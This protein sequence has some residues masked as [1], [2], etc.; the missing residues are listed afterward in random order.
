[1]IGSAVPASAARRTS[2]PRRWPRCTACKSCPRWSAASSGIRTCVTSPPEQSTYLLSPWVSAL[3]GSSHEEV[4]DDLSLPLDGNRS[5]SLEA[6]SVS[7]ALVCSRRHL[8]APGH[9]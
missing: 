2:E 6:V 1:M 9:S 4:R 8:D 7:E 3:L 5:P